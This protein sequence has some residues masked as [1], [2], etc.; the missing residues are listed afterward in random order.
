[1]AHTISTTYV[2]GEYADPLATEQAD[3][4]TTLSN[5]GA[6]NYYDSNTINSYVFP[7]LD[8]PWD[9]TNVSRIGDAVI[10]CEI[11]KLSKLLKYVLIIIINF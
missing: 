10:T 7:S 5:Q 1:M 9:L 6:N 2:T 4:A 8:T 3:C 11:V